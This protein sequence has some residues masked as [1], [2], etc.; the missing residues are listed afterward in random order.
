[1]LA[2]VASAKPSAPKAKVYR[3]FVQQSGTADPVATVRDNT[4]GYNVVWHRVTAGEY[5]IYPA[6]A[7]G[8][9]PGNGK[10]LVYFTGPGRNSKTWTLGYDGGAL[11]S[12]TLQTFEHDATT[13][14]NADGF[15]GW[16]E[17]RVY[18]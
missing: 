12:F 18:P 9:F 15:D 2:T 6:N 4:L 1:M 17:I 7:E 10:T 3:A 13:L 11:W 16:V 5:R 14:Q 8:K